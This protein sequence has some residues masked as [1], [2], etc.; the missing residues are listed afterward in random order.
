MAMSQA[1]LVSSLW[2][3]ALAT[4]VLLGYYLL[5]SL[6]YLPYLSQEFSGV[7]LG[8][9]LDGISQRIRP[10]LGASLLVFLV[11]GVYLMFGDA[12]YLGFG[13][14]GNSWSVLM[15]VKHVLVLA[16]VGLWAW[17]S[18]MLRRGMR[19]AAKAPQPQLASLGRIRLI[20]HA[21]SA[22]GVLVLLVTA[23]AQVA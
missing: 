7:A 22:C 18:A 8:A 21:T 13:R 19:V 11:S 3:H 16:M 2:L 12:N 4:V 15:L 6:V 14:F 10:W 9:A 5:L 1:L 23:V 17:L 20:V